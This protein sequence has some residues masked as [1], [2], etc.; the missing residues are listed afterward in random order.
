MISLVHSHYLSFYIIKVRVRW[1]MVFRLWTLYTW[2]WLHVYW[3]ICM[4]FSK[5]AF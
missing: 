1:P 3:E 2:A 4:G 5:Q